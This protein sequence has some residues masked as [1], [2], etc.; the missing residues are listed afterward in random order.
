MQVR[1]KASDSEVPTEKASNFAD[2]TGIIRNENQ[3]QSEDDNLKL[4]HTVRKPS[5][6]YY[7]PLGWDFLYRGIRQWVDFHHQEIWEFAEA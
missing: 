4:L 7:N 6:S 5:L 2:V 1:S 3:S